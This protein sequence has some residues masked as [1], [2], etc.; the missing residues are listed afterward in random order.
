MNMF[1]LIHLYGHSAPLLYPYSTIYQCCPM[2]LTVKGNFYLT[3]IC[4]LKSIEYYSCAGFAHF[5]HISSRN[6]EAISILHCTVSSK[7]EKPLILSLLKA[8]KALNVLISIRKTTRNGLIQLGMS[9]FHK[10]SALAIQFRDITP[11][12]IAVL[13]LVQS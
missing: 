11:N 9:S 13:A 10:Q 2:T 4:L 12:S 3:V 5:L 6:I 8:L 7:R 1:I